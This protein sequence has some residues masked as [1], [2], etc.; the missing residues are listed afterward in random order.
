MN[1]YIALFRGINVG[2]NHILPMKDLVAMMSA[3]GYANIQTYIQS[4]NMVFEAQQ[5]D[6]QAI[7]KDIGQGIF[8]TKGFQPRVL[9]LDAEQ[10]QQAIDLNPFPTEEGKSLHFF[11]LESP[12]T[13]PDIAKLD[14]VK[15]T[16]EQYQLTA[17]TFYL[18]APDGIG[19]SKLAALIG[20]ALGVSVTA[21]NWNTVNK[22]SGMLNDE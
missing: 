18:Y 4:G 22:L 6:R 7:A 16:T 10:W 13:Q 9:I 14:A 3:K 5:S 8:D 1:R 11:F 2:G 17:H 19:R 21:R 20:K 12:A 15:T